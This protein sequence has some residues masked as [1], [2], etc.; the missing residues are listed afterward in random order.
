MTGNKFKVKTMKIRLDLNQIKVWITKCNFQ[1]ID[2]DNLIAYIQYIVGI[3]KKTIYR[4]F[5]SSFCTLKY[6]S[7]LY[8]RF[9]FMALH[10]NNWPPNQWSMI[11]DADIGNTFNELLLG[12]VLYE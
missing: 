3:E 10:G 4:R 11:T 6:S 8:D 7:N 9:I 12:L 5:K 1:T 2:L